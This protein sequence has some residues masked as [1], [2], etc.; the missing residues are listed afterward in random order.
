MG[1][2]L[3]DN[4]QAIGNQY[5]EVQPS[6]SSLFKVVTDEIQK[7]GSIVGVYAAHK[8][9]IDAFKQ[10]E[11][12]SN[13][14]GEKRLQEAAERGDANARNLLAIAEKLQFPK[15]NLYELYQADF[16]KLYSGVENKTGDL[17]TD[18]NFDG[19][20]LVNDTGGLRTGLEIKHAWE[21][22]GTPEAKKQAFNNLLEVAKRQNTSL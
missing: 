4:L 7:Y 6:T 2:S 1:A 15:D 3:L 11:H 19:N 5:A 20:H 16:G 18:F 21:A 17:L 14:K 8:S 22:L 13:K 9:Q 12:V 10:G